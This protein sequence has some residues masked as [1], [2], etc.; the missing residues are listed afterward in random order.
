MHVAP[1]ITIF[2]GLNLQEEYLLHL[3]LREKEQE[4]WIGI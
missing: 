3:P 2:P 1:K 4:G